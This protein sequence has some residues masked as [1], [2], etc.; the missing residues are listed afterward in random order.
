MAKQ[1]NGSAA[2]PNPSDLPEALAADVLRAASG[3]FPP[4]LDKE[5]ELCPK[6]HSILGPM[7]VNDPAQAGKEN[8]RKVLREPLLMVSW[9]RAGGLWKWSLTD[10]VLNLAWDGP[11][12]SLVGIAEAVEA[13][14][15]E[16]RYRVKRKKVT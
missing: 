7:M 6:L 10:K 14:L 4:L 8:P 5:Q 1:K 16:G 2:A 12:P 3:C 13:C 15:V 9:D 11:L